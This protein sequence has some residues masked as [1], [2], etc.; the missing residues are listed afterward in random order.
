MD[1]RTGSL[2]TYENL[3]LFIKLLQYQMF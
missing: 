1:E 2:N 3:F